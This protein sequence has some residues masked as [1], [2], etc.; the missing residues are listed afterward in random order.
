MKFN[1]QGLIFDIT[2]FE[3]FKEYLF[4]QSPQLLR[5]KDGFRIYFSARK[6]FSDNRMPISEILYVD[7]DLD[8]KKVIGFS[9]KP[10][11]S[12]GILGSFDE[13]GAFPMH[14]KKINSRIFGYISG[15]SR[16]ISVPVETAIG[17]SESF[18]GGTSFTR[19]GPGPI[20]AA[21]QGEPFL[22]GDPFVL[23]AHSGLV[24]F[25]IAG[26]EW[27]SYENEVDPQRIYKIRSAYSVDGI[28]WAQKG[29][30]LIPDSLGQ[31]ECQ[32]L[33]TVI[34]AGE[35]NIMFFCYREAQGFRSDPKK[36]YKI[37]CAESLNLVDW[38]RKDEILEIESHE[39]SWDSEMKC[40]PHAT[41]LGNSIY[42][43]Y[44]G[45]SF[46]RNGFG[47]AI[48]KLEDSETEI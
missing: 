45:N 5:I 3:P 28:E 22:V 43:L 37:G 33:P 46:G 44:N 8:F 1:N 2:T 6:Q 13:H 10:V 9:T 29:E 42:L 35:R 17:I 15:W 14:V 12:P 11:L 20:L 40:Y 38:T 39:T 34:K 36:S 24:M 27:K 4:A 31:D 25:Y 48:H 18:D 30:N 23:E 26:T 41:V 19:L 32:A 16:R 7:F 47:L 21:S